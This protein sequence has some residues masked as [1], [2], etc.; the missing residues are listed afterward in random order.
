MSLDKKKIKYIKK[1]IVTVFAFF[2]HN[3]KDIYRSIIHMEIVHFSG[4]MC[5]RYH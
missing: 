4:T 2:E 5:T 3:V 1:K